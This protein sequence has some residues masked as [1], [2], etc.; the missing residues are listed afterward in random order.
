MIDKAA[1]EG[2]MKKA[3]FLHIVPPQVFAFVIGCIPVALGCYFGS[4]MVTNIINALSGRPIQALEVIG[5][6]LPAIGIAMNL[7]AI[8]KPGILLWYV[9]GFIIAVYLNLDTMPIAI[10][11][12]IVAYIYTGVVALAEE[13]QTAAATAGGFDDEFDDDFE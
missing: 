10:I 9:L 12:G 7:R 2:N 11:A 13:K 5:G 3:K 8:S 1:E 6:L 4:E